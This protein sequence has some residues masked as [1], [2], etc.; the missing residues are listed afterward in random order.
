MQPHVLVYYVTREVY[1]L[2]AMVEMGFAVFEVAINGT[3]RFTWE[4][5]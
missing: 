5:R 3:A 1:A 4:S 2:S